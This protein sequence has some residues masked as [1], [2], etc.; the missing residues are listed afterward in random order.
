MQVSKC[1]G[2]G[3]GF[4]G[5]LTYRLFANE[6]VNITVTYSMAK[7]FLPKDMKENAKFCCRFPRRLDQVMLTP[8]PTLAMVRNYIKIIEALQLRYEHEACFKL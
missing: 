1:F 8:N 7:P 2:V 6:G 4:G 5:T 3:E